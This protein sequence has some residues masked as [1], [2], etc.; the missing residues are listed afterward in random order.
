MS[1]PNLLPAKLRY[2][3]ARLQPLGRTAFWAS[4][5]G[6]LLLPLL[7]WQT[8]KDPGWLSTIRSYLV[9]DLDNSTETP[10]LSSEEL[11]ARL[12]DIDN[13]GVLLSEVEALNPLTP[14]ALTNKSESQ[15]SQG[16]F[17]QLTQQELKLDSSPELTSSGLTLTAPQN[18]KADNSGVTSAPGFLSNIAP[19][20]GNS[21][22]TNSISGTK[23]LSS[24]T[25]TSSSFDSSLSFLDSPNLNQDRLSI[26]PLEKA[27]SETTRVNSLSGQTPVNQEFGINQGKVPT[28]QLPNVSQGVTA[29]SPSSEVPLT[30]P[31]R[32]VGSSVLH[33]PE[34]GE[35]TA[36]AATIPRVRGYMVPPR[37]PS[38]PLNSSGYSDGASGNLPVTRGSAKFGRLSPVS[39][40]QT[41]GFTNPAANST[42]GNPGL[43]PIELGQPSV[44]PT[45]VQDTSNLSGQNR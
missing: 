1:P 13:S 39:P 25:K 42:L 45:P 9:G 43:K 27:L 34:T 3:K 29:T 19:L 17:S 24:T 20:S 11:A 37:T 30:Q 10:K 7:V 2:L 15:N 41:N 16:Y 26:S 5:I 35:I 28:P 33:N 38:A 12:V 32:K 23:E 22:F 31:L 36:P 14:K 8:G 21:M 40:A 44:Y 18:S 6:L 4:A